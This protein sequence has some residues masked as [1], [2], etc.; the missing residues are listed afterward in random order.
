MDWPRL[1]AAVIPCHNEAEHIGPLIAA[2]RRQLDYVLVVD[3]HSDDN[4]ARHAQA[5]G[6]EVFPAG[7]HRGKGYALRLGLQHVQARGYLWAILLDGD[8]QHSPEDLPQFFHRAEAGAVDLVVGNRMDNARTM[9]LL[10]RW[11]NRGMSHLLSRW[12][13]QSLPDTQCGFRLVRLAV[14]DRIALHTGC[15]EIESEMIVAFV[16]GGCRVRFVPIRTI[17]EQTRSKIRPLRDTVRWL[18]WARHARSQLKAA[19]GA[20]ACA[21]EE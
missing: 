4:T 11:T 1:C 16:A 8:G 19:R 15:F 18:V 5:A 6:A 9:P 7:E 3:D 14:L 21:L 12:L 10:R 2:L 13:G 17:Y 20:P